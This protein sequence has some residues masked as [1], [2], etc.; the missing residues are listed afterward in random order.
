MTL[1]LMGSGQTVTEDR[2]LLFDGSEQTHTM[3]ALATSDNVTDLSTADTFYCD[4][5]FYTC[6]SMFHQ[7][8][9]CTVLTT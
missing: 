3:I 9:I 4:G 2:F 7:I 8:Y 6:L 1:E 5:T